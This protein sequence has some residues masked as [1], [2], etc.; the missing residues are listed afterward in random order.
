MVENALVAKE[1]YPDWIIHLYHN[2]TCLPKVIDVLKTF[3]NVKLILI[4]QKNNKASNMLWRFYPAFNCEKE[5]IVIIR[6]C[7]S[8]L[9]LREKSAVEE[10]IN[11]DKDFHIMRDNP[12]HKSLIMGGMWGVKNGL[13]LPLKEKFDEVYL[14]CLKNDKRNLDQKWL[15]EIVYPY[16]KNN[17]II[18]ASF[19]RYEEGC[20][21]FKSNKYRFVGA[22]EVHAPRTRKLFNEE[23]KKLYRR[24][25]YSY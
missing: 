8:L 21:R 22:I 1:I 17:A 3:D 9:N 18:H 14:Q 10:F 13:L 7:D 23:N 25:L 12:S 16:V 2:E 19:N 4:N 24:P 5:D 6:D 20:L 15:S 11:S